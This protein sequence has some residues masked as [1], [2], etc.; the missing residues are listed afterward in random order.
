[1]IFLKSILCDIKKNWIR[2][3]VPLILSVLLFGVWFDR[4]STNEKVRNE[5]VESASHSV[6]LKIE[7]AFKDEMFVLSS[8]SRDWELSGG[9]ARKFWEKR[10][11]D[12]VNHFNFQAVSWNEGTYIRWIVPIKG[13][14]KAINRD[15][16]F[17]E[18]RLNAMN[19]SSETGEVSIAGPIDLIQGGKGL[20]LLSPIFDNEKCTGYIVGVIRTNDHFASIFN[21]NKYGV[22][23]SSSGDELYNS[24]KNYENSI[25]DKI[26]VNG[27]IF[28]IETSCDSSYVSN[29][30]S[31]G[32]G[33]AFILIWG[34]MF[35]VVLI[36]SKKS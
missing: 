25:I 8:M 21:D 19:R 20:L 4:L 16:S 35:S 23:I 17:S 26:V 24:E 10:S 7:T 6:K 11:L 34:V 29:A 14:E 2:Y 31:F 36:G 28:Q 32:M 13:N 30:Q 9:I 15:L 3:C 27:F 12:I 18:N 5:L 33:S 1:M 22:K